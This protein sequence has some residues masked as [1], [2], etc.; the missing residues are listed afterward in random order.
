MSAVYITNL[1]IE[2]DAGISIAHSESSHF[3]SRIICGDAVYP[4]EDAIYES[5]LPAPVEETSH[6]AIHDA[7]ML[8]IMPTS[9]FLNEISSTFHF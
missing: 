6:L 1:E 7:K 9:R 5:L 2:N 3:R 8:K 4:N